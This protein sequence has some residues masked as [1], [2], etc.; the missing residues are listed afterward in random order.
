MPTQLYIDTVSSTNTHLKHLSTLLKLEDGSFVCAKYQTAG[1]GQRGNFWESGFDQNLL[2]S[3]VLNPTELRA[4]SQ[5]IISQLVSLAIRDVLQQ[6]TS[7][8]T[9]KWPNDIY[10]KE[11][12]IAGILIENEVI[13]NCLK[14]S[15]IGI[16]LNLNQEQFESNAAN[17]ISLKQIT[18]Q[19]YIVSVILEKVVEQILHYYNY[20][21]V[22][23]KLDNIRI[24]YKK[25]LFRGEGFHLFEESGNS[26]SAQIEDVEDSGLLSLRLETG[27]IRKYAFKEVKYVI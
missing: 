19:T 25:A 13:D 10:W 9:I 15:V 8:I 22:A 27:E 6:Y 17:P 24:N 4:R 18:G 3:M 5:F 21:S 23:D 20:V 7:D 26:F 12:K 1:R 14:L 2:F 11:S 16:G